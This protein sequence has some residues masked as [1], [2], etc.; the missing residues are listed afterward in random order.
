MASLLAG[1]I[2]TKVRPKYISRTA[3]SLRDLKEVNVLERKTRVSRKE[4]DRQESKA[5]RSVTG[6]ALL[7][8]V[9]DSPTT[10]EVVKFLLERISS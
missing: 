6:L 3:V 1:Y 2:V 10:V 5:Q 7:Y 4:K 8:V 9:I